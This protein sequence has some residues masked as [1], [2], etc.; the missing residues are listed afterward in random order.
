MIDYAKT[1]KE[2]LED[3]DIRVELDDSNEKLGYKIR[4]AKME[5]VPYFAVIG[6][7][8]VETNTLS[9]KNR[10]D[11]EIKVTPEELVQKIL[12]ECKIK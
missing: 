1:V 9:I 10:K 12:E 7:K 5:K 6:A 2:K 11:E 4:N 8:E 3:N